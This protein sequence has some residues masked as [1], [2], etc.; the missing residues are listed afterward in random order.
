MI[1]YIL[2]L[3]IYFGFM[4]ISKIRIMNMLLASLTNKFQIID[5]NIMAFAMERIFFWYS[6]WKKI[7]VIEH[8]V[9]FA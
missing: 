6:Y 1:N 3:W 8:D 2:S 4:E 7:I 5:F 9:W